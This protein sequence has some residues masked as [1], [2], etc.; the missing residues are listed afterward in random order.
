[1]SLTFSSIMVE[2]EDPPPPLKTFADMKFPKII[3]KGLAKKGI[4]KPS[5]IQV[6]ISPAIAL[7]T[8]S[9]VKE[10]ACPRLSLIKDN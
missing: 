3:L 8:L 9:R 10:C 4:E 6:R 7:L 5:P 2:G 1:M